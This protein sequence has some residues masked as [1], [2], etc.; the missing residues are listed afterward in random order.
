MEIYL[1]Q[2]GPNLSKE[3][4]PTEPLSSEGEDC[5][6]TAAAA[7]QKMGLSFEVVI[8]SPK[9]RAQQT[10]AIV[11]EAIGYR[12]EDILI[13]D[14]VKAMTPAADT[15][16]YLSQFQDRRAV[17]IAG[18]L[19]S[20]AEV[21]SYLLTEGSRAAIHFLRGGLGRIDVDSLPTHS[22]EL[23]W[24]LTPEHLRLIAGQ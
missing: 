12:Q 9:K 14:K 17:F 8:A 13:T 23:Q 20:L 4:D 11:A 10:A 6:K 1:M 19:P 22:G 2:H 3:E 21:A 24:Y 7:I 5:I 16:Q 18:H 15:V